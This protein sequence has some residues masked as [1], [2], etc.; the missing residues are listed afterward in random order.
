MRPSGPTMKRRRHHA[1]AP[2]RV[3]PS[4][5]T[6][7]SDRQVEAG[8]VEEAPHAR[9]G[10]VDV[11]REHDERLARELVSQALHR[12][13]LVAARLAPRRPE[14]DEHDFAAIPREIVS[15]AVRCPSARAAARALAAPGA[16]AGAARGGRK[17]EQRRRSAAATATTP[18]L[19]I[20]RISFGCL[21]VEIP[22]SEAERPQRRE[23]GRGAAATT[24]R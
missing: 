11:D 22:Q 23:I 5:S 16:S 24:T 7:S 18:A 6:S 9:I 17:R 3:S 15:R 21:L 14:V 12:R 8:L 1:H 4:C 10:L 20:A 19:Q 13:H 2:C